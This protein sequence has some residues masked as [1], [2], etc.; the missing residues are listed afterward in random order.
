MKELRKCPVCGELYIAKRK[1]KMTCSPVC[2]KRYRKEEFKEIMTIPARQ[3]FDLRV[4]DFIYAKDRNAESAKDY[5]FRITRIYDH[6]FEAEK[7]SS[8]LIRSWTK[9]AYTAGEVRKAE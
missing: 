7:L 8:G 4:G 9:G 2:S 5:K 3:K 6:F 1:D